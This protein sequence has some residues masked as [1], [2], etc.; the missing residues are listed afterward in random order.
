[1]RYYVQR[2]GRIEGPLTVDEINSRI[3]AGLVDSEWVATSDLGDNLDR[4]VKSREHDW[5]SVAEIPGII[6]L[7]KAGARHNNQ[8]TAD[9]VRVAWTVLLILVAFAVLFAIF[10]VLRM[11]NW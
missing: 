5:V 3:A 10:Q 7:A 11:F 4:V 8:D 6:G 1:M 2:H 9:H